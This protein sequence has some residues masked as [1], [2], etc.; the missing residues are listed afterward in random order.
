VNCLNAHGFEGLFDFFYAPLDFSSACLLGYAF[1]NFTHHQH[2][3]RAWQLFKGE[4]LVLAGIVTSAPALKSNK[5][6]EVSWARIQGLDANLKH[7]KNSPVNELAVEF[8]PMRVDRTTV[9]PFESRG[10]AAQQVQAYQQP[11]SPR[12]SGRNTHGKVAG[13]KLFVGGL[14]AETTSTSLRRYFEKYGVVEEAVV[15]TNKD[16]GVS[17]GFGFCTFRDTAVAS[18]VLTEVRSHSIDGIPVAVRSYTSHNNK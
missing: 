8:R 3:M 1:V 10:A 16:T 13:G 9:T 11:R 18:R 2:A 5:T 7:Y 4:K 12:S 14:A 6:C 17:R 15:M